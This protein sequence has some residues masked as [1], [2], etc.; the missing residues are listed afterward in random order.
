MTVIAHRHLRAGREDGC[1][2]LMPGEQHPH[3]QHSSGECSQPRHASRYPSPTASLQMGFCPLEGQKNTFLTGKHNFNQSSHRRKAKS[4]RLAVQGGP[5]PA[6]VPPREG[7]HSL[8]SIPG[9]VGT[10]PPLQR[11][12]C[13][14]CGPPREHP[15]PS[16]ARVELKQAPPEDRQL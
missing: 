8:G 2:L 15:M 5:S 11:V 10:E 16:A 13:Q 12:F 14:G 9:R 7:G 4:S 1:I 6:A 3:R